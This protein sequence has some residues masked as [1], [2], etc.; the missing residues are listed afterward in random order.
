MIKH[1]NGAGKFL[2]IFAHGFI[3]TIIMF[4]YRFY[5]ADLLPEI[6]PGS[7]VKIR[8]VKELELHTMEMIVKKKW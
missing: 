2:W 1:I 6:Q 5:K 4:M 3:W 7:M 8:A